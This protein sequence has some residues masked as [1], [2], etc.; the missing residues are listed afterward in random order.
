MR[1][2]VVTGLGVVSPLGA[3]VAAN[4]D[5]LLMGQSG[6]GT[7]TR[8]DSSSIPV[9]IDGEVPEGTESGKLDLNQVAS[10]KDQ[11]HFDRVTLLGLAAADE[12]MRDCGYKPETEEEKAAFGVIFGSGQGGAQSFRDGAATVQKMGAMKISPFF[13]PSILINQTAGQISI[14][15]GLAGPN[16]ACSTACATGSHAIG[17]AARLIKENYADVMLAG[18]SEAALLL[19][20]LAGFA[21]LRALSTHNDEPQ[22][23]SRPWDK[24][25]DGF[26]MG[27]GAGALVLEEYEHAKAR[28]AKIYAEVV[29]Y[30]LSG[31]AYHI[32]APGGT[33]AERAMKMALRQAEMNPEEVDYINA[34]GT[35]TPA[36]DLTEFRA[37]K[38]V[39]GDYPV[40]MSS[41][42]SMTGHLL[43]GAG[44]VEGVFSVLALMNNVMPPTVNLD[45]PEEET[46]GFNLVPHTAQE[47]PLRA[48]LS[49]S[50]GFG[51]TNACLIFKKV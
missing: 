40:A 37:V 13:I 31:D 9:H 29:G 25:R 35:S 16:Q 50:F 48:V 20:C 39:F 24:A 5:A 21:Q 51:G 12:A 49:N 19:E 34:H 28:G 38:Q 1:R 11:R 45:D 23:A 17:D 14:R 22:K 10:P 7:I 33:G 27:E 2:V 47:K 4:W 18:S 36:G 44:S 41:T 46:K 30:G 6:I 15:Y 32:T 8:F 43:G 26:V 3:G 42:K